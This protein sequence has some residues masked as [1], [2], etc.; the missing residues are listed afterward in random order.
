M[1]S[2]QHQRSHR[3]ARSSG[4]SSIPSRLT[5]ACRAR[6]IDSEHSAVA[7]QDDER[8]REL[9][10]LFNLKRHPDAGRGDVDA[11]LELKGRSVP[12]SLRGE[13][14]EFELKS[15]TGGKPT[16][17]TVRDFGLH[18]I[19][20]W[21]TMHWLFGIYGRDQRGDQVL[22]YCMYGSPHQMRPWFDRMASYVEPDVALARH[23][24]R[25]ITDATLSAV[26]GPEN[27]FSQNDAKRLMKNQYSA[28]DYLNASDR[29]DG[30]YSRRAM[31]R[32]LRERA[33]YVIERGSTLNNPHIP[34]GYFVGWERIV[35][36][37]AARL[38]E[39]V[40]HALVS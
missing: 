6:P 19:E 32:M 18:H 12:A 31:L 37:H 11:V 8:E 35:D 17:S 23:V 26:L 7:A 2:S 36:D 22:L 39:L 21:R 25:L 16:I 14:I 29:T 10:T 15:A 38:R 28:T 20:K 33:K 9:R 4:P 13:A 24:P 27:T 1:I 5:K 34:A 40:V 3:N 30:G